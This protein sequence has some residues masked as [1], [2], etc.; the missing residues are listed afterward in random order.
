MRFLEN[1]FA[2]DVI[3]LTKRICMNDLAGCTNAKSQKISGQPKINWANKILFR[4]EI[5]Q[6]KST[7]NQEKKN[8]YNLRIGLK[9]IG[10]K[11]T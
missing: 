8:K 11:N 4:K 7:K 5:H 10:S 6:N 1:G 9:I 2:V 3:A